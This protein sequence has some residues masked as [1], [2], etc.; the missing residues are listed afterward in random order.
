M[1]RTFNTEGYC[2]SQMHYMVDL[3]GWLERIRAMVDAEKYFTINRARQYGKTTVLAALAEYL[4]K[5]YEVI[6]LDFQGISYADFVSEQNFVAA[7]S[8]QL[9]LCGKNMP[10]D[11]KA[12]FEQYADH[13][14]REMTISA[15][16]ILLL[17]WCGNSEKRSYY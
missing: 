14:V 15:L 17:K 7:F 12:E 1:A 10:D 3:T 5:D 9:L 2:D 13:K 11:L 4:K 8:R 6:S 16:F